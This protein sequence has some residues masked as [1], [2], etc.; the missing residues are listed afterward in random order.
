MKRKLITTGAIGLIAALTLGACS[1]SDNPG[2]ETTDPETNE[3]GA[4]TNGSDDG[5][6]D[7][8]SDEIVTLTVG[9][10]ITPH[11]ASLNSLTQNLPPMPG[12]IWKSLSLK[13]RCFPM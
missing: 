12:L 11:L 10:S 8:D 6:E 4:E 2:P 3:N 9:A 1:N 13:I 7:G 5:T